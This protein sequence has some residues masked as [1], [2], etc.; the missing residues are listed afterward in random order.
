MCKNRISLT[1]STIG[2]INTFVFWV[3]VFVVVRLRYSQLL[4]GIKNN[5][6]IYPI[7]VCI[8]T[9]AIYRIQTVA[10]VQMTYIV[11]M[12]LLL[13]ENHTGYMY[14]IKLWHQNSLF[15]FKMHD[16]GH[17]QLMH[18]VGLW[19]AT[20]WHSSDMNPVVYT[21]YTHKWWSVT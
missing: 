8:N 17:R 2:Q 16:C 3:L 9:Q 14:I 6:I 15:A 20:R 11:I 5:I 10:M 12:V 21:V 4:E 7:P 18:N 1:I 13:N 19:L